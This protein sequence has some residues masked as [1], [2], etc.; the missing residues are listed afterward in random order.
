MQAFYDINNLP[1][2]F[3]ACD[4]SLNILF[5][6][7]DSV[8]A[9]VVKKHI[10]GIASFSNHNMEIVSCRNKIIIDVI[11]TYKV[12][13]DVIIIHYS[14]HPTA[15]IDDDWLSFVADFSGPVI[16]IHEDE[17]QNINKI[18]DRFSALGVQYLISCLSSVKL[19]KAVYSNRVNEDCIFS[20]LARLRN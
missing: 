15:Y 18:T 20:L 2:K 5:L 7:D 14:I 13:Y 12:A 17:Y 4:A 9:H 6:A 10:K 3:E 8:D 19:L 11:D 1:G 16:A